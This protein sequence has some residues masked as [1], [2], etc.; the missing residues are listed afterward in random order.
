MRQSH[1][2]PYPKH[3][4]PHT[5]SAKP[6]TQTSQS[7]APSTPHSLR[8]PNPQPQTPTPTNQKSPPP[9]VGQREEQ[10]PIKPPRAPQRAV[11]RVRAV[12]RADDDDAAP[13]VQPVHQR[14]QRGDD[15]VVDLVLLA[16]ADGGEAVDLGGVGWG[17]R[18]FVLGVGARFVGWGLGFGVGLS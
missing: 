14:Q 11:Q 2:K 15:A 9:P 8:A 17:V 12:G 1:A 3:S 13:G 6:P 18:R 7:P 10:L 16:A 5:P 4:A